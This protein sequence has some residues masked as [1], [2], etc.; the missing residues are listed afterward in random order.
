MLARNNPRS[1]T[2]GPQQQE[3]Y[4]TRIRAEVTRPSSPF[5]TIPGNLPISKALFIKSFCPALFPCPA[6]PHLFINRERICEFSSWAFLLEFFQFMCKGNNG[7]VTEGGKTAMLR[8]FKKCLLVQRKKP[9]K[10][11][12]PGHNYWR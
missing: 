2:F 12:P 10:D 11:C 4:K 5:I 8:A 9:L 6:D 1:S 7:R 3:R